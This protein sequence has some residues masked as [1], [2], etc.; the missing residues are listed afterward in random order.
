MQLTPADDIKYKND[1]KYKN[2]YPVF[3]KE[4][5][6]VWNWSAAVDWRRT[7]IKQQNKNV[8]RLSFV[9]EYV[10]KYTMET[11]SKTNVFEWYNL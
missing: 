5:Q 10:N 4:L 7:Y 9:F 1:V 11:R 3:M 2:L 6:N 8:N